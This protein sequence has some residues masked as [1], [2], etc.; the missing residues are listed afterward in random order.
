MAMFLS[1]N[2]AQGI[3]GGD[4]ASFQ[5]GVS[6]FDNG[7]TSPEAGLTIPYTIDPEYTFLA[8]SAWL[9]CYADSGIV[10]H[11]PLPQNKY[12]FDTLGNSDLNLKS[13]LDSIIGN[14]P[15][16]SSQGNWTDVVQ[17]MANTV[18]K[19]CLK[20][21]AYRVA[22]QPVFPFLVSVTSPP[23]PPLKAIPDDSIPQ[24]TIGPV[25]IGNN[26]GVPVYYAAWAFWYTVTGL[27]NAP[28]Q[29]RITPPPNYA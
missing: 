14:G 11:R 24:H 23:L 6:D 17:R 25:V 18:V 20:G 2:V 1:E 29:G 8:Y 12:P 10:V 16:L 5:V 19:I 13:G 4:S 7:G 27:P 28:S 22:Y 15:N 9:E 3:G 26:S 21:Y